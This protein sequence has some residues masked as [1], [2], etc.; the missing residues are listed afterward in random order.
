MEKEFNN[1]W[2]ELEME[3]KF[4]K[5]MNLFRPNIFNVLDKKKKELLTQ[6]KTVYNFSVGTP[7]FVP[8]T[9]VMN[10]LVE[11]GK[12][13]DNYKYALSDRDELLKSVITWYKKRYNVILAE[14]EITSVYGSQEGISRICSVLCDPEDIVL[15]PNPGYPIFEIGPYLCGAK[16]MTYDLSPEKNYILDF[17]DIPKEL[18]VKAKVII[19][20]YP[21]NPVCVVA[22]DEFYDNLIK[23]AK[24]NNIIVIHDNAYSEI[25]YDGIEGKSF[26]SY[27]GAKEVGIEFNSLSKTYNLTGARVS[28]ALGNKDIINKFRILRSQVDYGMFL[29]IQKVAEAALNGPQDSIER[30]K[31]EYEK[32]RDALY[33]GLNKIGWKVNKS[34]GTMFLWGKIPD[35]YTNSEKFVLELLEKTGVVVVPGSSFG[36][37]G[38]GYVRFALVLPVEEINRALKVIEESGIVEG[39]K[40]SLY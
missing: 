22:P 17:D 36:S 25:V 15:V 18:A 8:D 23:F 31:K 3:I 13:P 40:F 27:D 7:D 6:G 5:K 26:L 28:F 2:S 10:A 33:L 14:E 12:N 16:V 11:A 32:R 38:E 20:S 21:L 4:S 19:V 24:E 1:N 34:Q 35:K 30:N 39:S 37:L 29:P 9:H